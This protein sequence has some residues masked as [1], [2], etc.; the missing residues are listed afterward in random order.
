MIR[1]TA[2]DRTITGDVALGEGCE[3]F[4]LLDGAG[5]FSLGAGETHELTIGFRPSLIGQESC[6]LI[7]GTDCGNKRI[8]GAGSTPCVL[9]SPSNADGAF[10]MGSVSVGSHVEKTL[11]I[12]SIA[13]ERIDGYVRS[14]DANFEVI[15]GGGAFSIAPGGEYFIRVRFAPTSRGL[16]T[17]RLQ[18]G[19]GCGAV[20]LRGR[21]AGGEGEPRIALH[22]RAQAAKA[23]RICTTDAPMMPCT[24]YNVSGGNEDAQ[25][26][27]VVATH[28]P[29]G[30]GIAAAS[31]AITYL[32]GAAV[33]GWTLCAD[34]DAP[35]PGWLEP[36]EGNR[37]M[38]DV[39]SNCQRS[40]VPGSADLGVHAVLGAFYV[41]NYGVGSL[42]LVNRS[43]TSPRALPSW[44][45]ICGSLLCRP[46]IG[47]VSR[48]VPPRNRAATPA[49]NPAPGTSC[50]GSSR[51]CSNSGTSGSG[52]ID[53]CP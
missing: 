23:S 24:E 1:N 43:T 6:E 34:T 28:V 3:D 49:S 14:P 44:T 4:E 53:P 19:T 11:I 13:T 38:F 47:E 15:H 22:T 17:C 25:T 41:Y 32:D 39:D 42:G 51:A 8:S 36:G 33:F 12:N 31:F 18:M 21:G 9:V 27:Y 16:K 30:D 46:A 50:V 35:D 5:P 40:T 7:L 26:V 29:P 37:V 48:S 2:P 52:K 10:E 45:A 20:E